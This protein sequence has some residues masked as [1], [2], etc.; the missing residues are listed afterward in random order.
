ML[1]TISVLFLIV[2]FLKWI[3]SEDPKP[4]NGVYSQPGKWFSVKFWLFY[5]M[6]TLR[7]RRSDQGKVK[8]QEDAGFGMKSRNSIEEMDCAQELPKQHAT[9][10]NLQALLRLDSGSLTFDSLQRHLTSFGRY[11]GCRVSIPL[12]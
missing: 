8:G 1:Y 12:I 11:T 3:T 2:I 4:I 6:I 10:S 5:L 7:K 9:V